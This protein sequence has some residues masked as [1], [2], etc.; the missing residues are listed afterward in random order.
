EQRIVGARADGGSVEFV[1]PGILQP[2]ASV[3]PWPARRLATDKR[4]VG[5]LGDPA[6]TVRTEAAGK[7]AVQADVGSTPGVEVL[8]G[9]YDPVVVAVGERGIRPRFVESVS[10]VGGSPGEETCIQLLVFISVAAAQ[11]EPKITA[12]ILILRIEADV[13]VFVRLR[14]SARIRW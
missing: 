14:E 1:V 7:S 6:V 8:A 3:E 4:D 2:D 11:R 9:E 5:D 10:R 13:G 12:L